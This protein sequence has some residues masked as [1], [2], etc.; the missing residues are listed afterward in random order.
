MVRA[1]AAGLCLTAVLVLSR[2]D[3]QGPASSVG[4]D[5]AW[6]FA[7]SGVTPVSQ[8][9]WDVLIGNGWNYLRRTG[10]KDADIIVDRT[11]PF[12]GQQALRIIFTPD[13]QRDSEPSVH[14][15]AVP[16]SKE[17]YAEWWMKLS[18]N[19]TSSPAGGGKITFLWAPGGLGQVYTGIFGA[20]EPHHVS[21][22]TEWKP[23]G[24]KIWEPNVIRT[25]IFYDRWY[26]IGWRMKWATAP[27]AQDGTLRWSVD[28]VLNGSYS[29][30]RFPS[31]DTGFQ[32]FEFAPTLQNP[33][34][35]EQYMYIGPTHVGAR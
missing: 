16:G 27:G 3:R 9:V 2:C 5:P 31:S 11:A 26:R 29:D 8:H 10:S 25:P 35:A 22:N 21:V 24:Q 12:P 19:W 32:Q 30:V 34:P 23:Y 7:P 18:A 13:M 28:G 17:V 4:T 14:W 33:P 6:T 20:R 15:V 1:S